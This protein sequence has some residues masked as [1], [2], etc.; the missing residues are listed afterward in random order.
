MMRLVFLLFAEEKN[1][2][3][4]SNPVYHEHYALSTIHAQ[5]RQAADDH[6]EEVLEHRYDTFPRLLATFRAVHGGVEHDLFTLPPY[7]VTC[8]I[9]TV[10]PFS[11]AVW[12]RPLGAIDRRN[13]MVTNRT[14]LHLLGA[15][16][17]LK[18]KVR[19]GG[20]E[21]RQISFALDMSRS[22]MFTKAFWTIQRSGQVNPLWAWRVQRT[23]KSAFRTRGPFTTTGKRTGKFGRCAAAGIRTFE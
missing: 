4:V 12:R 2:L 19:G 6:G 15:L 8:S 9:Q 22:G 7:G 1:L 10:T 14:V 3:P 20:I 5:L 17:F 18:M 23:R 16:Q 13:R 21:K 11:N